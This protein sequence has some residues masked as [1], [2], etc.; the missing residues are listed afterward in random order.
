MYNLRAG[1]TGLAHVGDV[2]VHM[3]LPCASLIASN[4]SYFRITKTSVMQVM[5]GDYIIL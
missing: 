1:N 2:L 3:I 4:P 5:A